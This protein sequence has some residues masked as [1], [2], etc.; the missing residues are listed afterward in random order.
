MEPT[1][2]GFG[3][4]AIYS[5]TT[6]VMDTKAALKVLKDEL[7]EQGVNIN[8]NEQFIASKN[9]SSQKFVETDK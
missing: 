4:Q 2:V 8:L 6:S 9:I 3:S 7:I 5:P 1:L